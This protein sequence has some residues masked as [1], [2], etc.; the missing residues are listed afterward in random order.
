MRRVFVPVLLT[1]T[2]AAACMQA[3]SSNDGPPPIAEA[4]AGVRIFWDAYIAAAT[5]GNATALSQLHAADVFL[6]E[7]G[8]PTLRG[9]DAVA[10]A[11]GEGFKA[12]QYSEVNI[13]PELTEWHGEHVFQV[14]SYDDRFTVQGQVTRTFGR[15]AGVFV[16]D[17]T[18]KWLVSRAVVA[19]DSSA[20][21]K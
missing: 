16:R 12:A 13:R 18:G 9:R 11:F 8:M 1:S 6:V 19:M 17:S 3:G 15:Y 10:A 7:P 14:G 21:V 2:L 20:V 4:E 5:S